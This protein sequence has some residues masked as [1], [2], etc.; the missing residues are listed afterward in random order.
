MYE[1]NNGFL[2]FKNKSLRPRT[3]DGI[4]VSVRHW[5]LHGFAYERLSHREIRLPNRLTF[6]RRM[7]LWQIVRTCARSPV[8]IKIK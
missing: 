6:V 1:K 3:H 7:T 8:S 4:T 2:F 5:Q